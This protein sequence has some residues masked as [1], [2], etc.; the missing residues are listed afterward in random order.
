M[1][2]AAYQTKNIRKTLLHL[3]YWIIV[4]IVFLIERS[5]LIH[6]AG[7]PYFIQCTVVRVGLLVCISY[8]NGY[9][10]MPTYLVKKKYLNYFIWIVALIIGYVIFQS[11][12][13]YYLY[14]YLLGSKN[15]NLYIVLLL[16]SLNTI[17]YVI[18][19]VVF[20]I[21][22]DWYEQSQ[23]IRTQPEQLQ[24]E[25]SEPNP[26]FI[27]VKSGVKRIKLYFDQITHIQ[28][29]KDYAIIYTLNDK[30]V[31]KGSVKQVHELLPSKDF[32]R[33]HKSYLVAKN[34]INHIERGRI[35]FG[36][37]QIP[38]GRNY[39]EAIIGK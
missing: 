30:I 7:L 33:V 8:L 2:Q 35:I 38:I 1:L 12:Y 11:F 34:K 19:S 21:C 26:E 5:Y 28:G 20:K 23:I 17:W 13:D 16:H 14:G 24:L 22:I 3:G 29:L 10:L 6:K 4:T 15:Q 31:V 39:R 18:L 25:P 9:W 36:G 37:H 32:I 27:F